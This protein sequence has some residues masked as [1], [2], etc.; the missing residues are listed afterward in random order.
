MPLIKLGCG[1]A[2]RPHETIK[3][4]AMEEWADLGVA[5]VVGAHDALLLRGIHVQRLEDGL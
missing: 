5:D 3:H 4:V 1:V 2:S